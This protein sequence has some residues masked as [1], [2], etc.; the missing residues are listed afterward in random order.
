MT[1]T[2]PFAARTGPLRNG[3]PRGNPDLAPR[4]GAGTRSGAAC[5]SP[6]M[7]NGRC[8]MHGGR[9][10]GPTSPAGRERARTAATRHG[11]HSAAA[12]EEVRADREAARSFRLIVDALLPLVRAAES[13][14][15]ALRRRRA[16]APGAAGE[17]A[18][19]AALRELAR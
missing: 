9:S 7:A 11:L 13:Q 18:S 10:T 1:S 17:H 3:N 16:P 15:H 12:M 5:R 4:C 14:R 19:T 8:R 2:E 6:A